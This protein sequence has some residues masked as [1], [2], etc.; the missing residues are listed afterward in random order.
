MSIA[1]KGL[2]L[3]SAAALVVMAGVSIAGAARG[4]T[5]ASLVAGAVA[6]GKL[7]YS[8]SGR[9]SRLYA[10]NPD[11]SGRRVL[12][13]CR[14]LNCQIGAYAWSPGGKRLAFLR[15][16]KPNDL[17]LFVVGADGKGE[18]R[19]AGCGKPKWPT[20]ADFWGRLSWSPDGSRLV[21][22]RAGALLI[23]N[24]NGV[25]FRRLT[26]CGR[27]ASCADWH[28]SWAPSGSRIAFARAVEGR[29]SIYAVKTAGSDLRRLTNLTG[30]AGEPVW[31]PDGSRIAF[32][33]SGAGDG[34]GIYAMAADGSELTLLSSRSGHP[35]W[36]PDGTEIVS[37]STPGSPGAYNAEVWV[38]KADGSERRRPYQGR[39]CIG[40]WAAPI[41]S[42]DGRYIAF[43]DGQLMYDPAHS[44]IFVMKADGTEL[45]KLTTEVADITWQR[46]P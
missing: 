3:G 23:V 29:R 45:R 27:A 39:C 19:L 43:G 1:M 26:R 10:V 40:S 4:V 14:S 28:P 12:A 44:G 37:F 15:G 8:S 42:P 22:T 31:S 25:G 34:D 21:L 30:H 6:N 16:V 24:V 35:H 11:G 32:G 2:I 41:W 46:K 20:C 33:V 13:R 18:R 38:I 36:S 17:S 7:A 5:S 9:P